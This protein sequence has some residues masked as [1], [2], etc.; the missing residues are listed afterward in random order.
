MSTLSNP[1]VE[2][3]DQI[4]Y[5]KPNSLTFKTGKGDRNVRTQSAGGNSISVVV[6][7]NAETKKSMV[8]FTLITDQPNLDSLDV[9]LDQINSQGNTIRLSDG[10]FTIPFTKMVVTSEPERG[11]GADGE[12][13]VNF[14]GPPVA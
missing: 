3:N 14:E 8:K 5:I 2:V 6:T 11:T 7:D 9:W 10:D 13:E 1:T 4:V 12:T